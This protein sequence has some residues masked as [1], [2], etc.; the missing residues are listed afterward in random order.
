ML[1]SDII[2]IAGKRGYGKTTLAKK[3]VSMMPRVAIYDLMG[4][5]EHKYAYIPLTS[6]IE[7]FDNWLK[8]LWSI[9]N[10]F[11]LVDESDQIAPVE[12][13]LSPYMNKI[14]NLGRHRGIGMGLVTRR[15]ARLNKTAFSQSTE[16]FLFHHF[17][18]NDLKYLKEFFPDADR[19]RKL[20]KYKYLV[21]RG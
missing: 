15:I 14:I 11:I 5:Y 3:I 10:V 4:E 1:T 6:S 13:P 20:P 12:K 7:E 8:T 19:I 2:T 16:V 9:G 21:F 18:P 17:V